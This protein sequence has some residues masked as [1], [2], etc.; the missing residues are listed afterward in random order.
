MK[1]IHL[2]LIIAI[3]IL[4]YLI[5]MQWLGENKETK[6]PVAPRPVVQQET[7][8]PIAPVVVE[9][10]VTDTPIIE[11]PTPEPTPIVINETKTDNT[12]E[13][14]KVAEEKASIGLVEYKNTN[15]GYS[16]S[17]SDKMYYAGFGSR[18]GAV[19]TL[20]IQPEALPETFED[21]TIRVYYYGKKAL[22]ELKNSTQYTDPNGKYILLLLD[23]AYSVKIESDNLKS[24]T[25]QAILSTIKKD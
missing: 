25:V 9:T 14:P 11:T 12:T 22:P 10:P 15:Y 1:N 7:E 4:V 13:T 21:G 17:L 18:D 6:T 16:F 2:V 3:L 24:P 20:A 8:T 19:H 23:G 5:S